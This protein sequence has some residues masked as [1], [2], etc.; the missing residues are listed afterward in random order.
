MWMMCMIWR[1]GGLGSS[2]IREVGGWG[3][4]PLERWGVFDIP[5]TLYVM[6]MMCHMPYI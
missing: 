5:Y 6:W 3:R 2:T 1:G 4:V